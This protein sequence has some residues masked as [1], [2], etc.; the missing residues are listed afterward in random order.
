MH[1][2]T[3][4]SLYTRTTSFAFNTA[5][6]SNRYN[7]CLWVSRR[8]P[9]P[10][11]HNDGCLRVFLQMSLL[12]FASDGRQRTTKTIPA[13]LLDPS[14]LILVNRSYRPV[15]HLRPRLSDCINQDPTRFASCCINQD[16]TR[17]RSSI[18]PRLSL[19]SFPTAVPRCHRQILS[20]VAY[21]VPTIVPQSNGA[22]R[23][24]C[25]DSPKLFPRSGS[26]IQIAICFQGLTYPRLIS[27]APRI[28]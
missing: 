26:N 23:P 14:H 19:D 27:N 8:R 3:E 24:S 20:T 25:T 2:E 18:F 4:D 22:S 17:P 21:P 1:I 16:P 15:L 9:L 7:R 11:Q 6:S 13:L 5:P 10:L 12:C 28:S